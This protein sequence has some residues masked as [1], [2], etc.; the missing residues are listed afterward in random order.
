MK[1]I[2]L[3]TLLL[4]LLHSILL[5]NQNL[6]INVI[7]FSIPLLGWIVYCLKENKCIKNKKGLLWILP[8][9]LLS[10]TYFVFDHVLKYLNIVVIP[11]LY[12]LM[13]IYTMRPTNTIGDTIVEVLSLMI[14]PLNGIEN[15]TKDLIKSLGK[16]KKIS[17]KT[18]KVIQSILIVLPIIIVVLILLISADSIFGNLFKHIFDFEIDSL[19]EIIIRIFIFILLFF[20]LGST[21]YFLTNNY[22]KETRVKKEYKEKDALTINILLISL[23]VIYVI[24]DIIQ[25]NSLLLHRVA[26]NF[27]YAAYA[28]SGFFQLMIISVIN[29]IIVLVSK[30]RKEESKTKVMSIIMIM[31]TYIIIVSSFYRMFLYEQ[32]YGYTVLRLGVYVLLITE[33][34]L[35]IPTI[36]YIMNKKVNILNWYMIISITI[37]CII[38]CCSVDCIIAK[39]NISRYHK[40]GKIDIDY[41]KNGNYDNLN[42]LRELSKTIEKDNHLFEIE[43]DNL[44]IYINRMDK[45]NTTSI[46]EYNIS[47]EKAK[48]RD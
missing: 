26:S 21:M 4:C 33:A 14:K 36:V 31:L 39:N 24:F 44:K 10:G 15:F 45:R 27:N 41:L 22:L 30:K 6:G 34:I 3:V 32:A 20:Y 1:K 46:L 35:L 11:V 13:Y 25:I 29:I 9:I 48:K 18:K 7:L 8:I 37:Y 12:L 16:G 19:D 28:R 38:N 2:V 47:K 23:D 5:V 42:Q 17:P 43:K 40:T